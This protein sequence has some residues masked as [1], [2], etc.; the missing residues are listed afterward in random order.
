MSGDS[1]RRARSSRKPGTR[2]ALR[3]ACFGFGTAM[4]GQRSVRV[5]GV[6]CALAGA[7]PVIYPLLPTV[8]P[9]R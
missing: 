4:S 9:V 5:L 7:L 2:H 3:V 8:W 1:H 6:S